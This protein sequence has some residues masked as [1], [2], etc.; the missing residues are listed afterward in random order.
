MPSSQLLQKAQLEPLTLA[1]Y[2]TPAACADTT[3]KAGA[4]LVGRQSMQTLLWSPTRSHH[5]AHTGSPA[6]TAVSIAANPTASR[7]PRSYLRISL[8]QFA[9]LK[10][11]IIKQQQQGEKKKKKKAM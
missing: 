3:A 6:P 9:L 1:V 10:I 7:S 11:I 2:H 8:K 5:T 4:H